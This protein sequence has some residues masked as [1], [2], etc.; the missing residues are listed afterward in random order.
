MTILGKFVSWRSFPWLQSLSFFLFFVCLFFFFKVRFVNFCN[1]CMVYRSF[2]INTKY[3]YILCH[4]ISICRHKSNKTLCWLNKIVRGR[5]VYQMSAALESQK[6]NDKR[7]GALFRKIDINMSLDPHGGSRGRFLRMWSC[8]L[9]V[10]F[11]CMYFY[12][13]NMLEC[14]R[15]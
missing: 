5:L 10:L 3:L 7:D 12:V 1:T 4:S 8:I 13:I 6:R 14:M 2:S 9:K 11:R 15:L